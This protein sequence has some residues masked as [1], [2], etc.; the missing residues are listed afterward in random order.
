MKI[1]EI[2]LKI[3]KFY[4]SQYTERQKLMNIDKEKKYAK[5]IQYV[6]MKCFCISDGIW[7]NGFMYGVSGSKVNNVC[8]L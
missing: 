5:E 2:N 6:R 3:N 7:N 8:I 1:Q 4:Y